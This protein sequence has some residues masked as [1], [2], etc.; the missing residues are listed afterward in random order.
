MSMTLY[1]PEIG[2]ILELEQSWTF[3]LFKERRNQYLVDLFSLGEHPP[4]IR[5]AKERA[6]RA[7]DVYRALYRVRGRRDPEVEAAYQAWNQAL[8]ESRNGSWSVTLPATTKLK[9][10]RIY[11]RVGVSAYSSLTFSVVETPL[12]S[13]I[14]KKAKGRA[15]FWAKLT[16]V[17][18]MVIKIPDLR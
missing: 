3:R 11:I 1:V 2:D 5:E 6:D 13:P 16:D 10:A 18:K 12:V 14:A 4:G 7:G 9:V 8:S 17:N 15:A